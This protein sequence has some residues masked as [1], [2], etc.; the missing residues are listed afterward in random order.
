M[1][2]SGWTIERLRRE[3]QR[4]PFRCGEPALDE[5]LHK[6]AHQN[7]EKGIGRTFVATRPGDLVVL[8]YSTLRSGSVSTTVLQEA[9]RRHLPTYPVP[10]VHLGRL[11]VDQ[12][13]QGRRLG[14][15]LLVDALRRAEAASRDVAAYAVEV[16]A[17]HERAR[18]F[19]LKYGFREMTDDR[20]HRYLAMK[21]VKVLTGD[22]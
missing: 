22:E 9:D 13:M 7:D 10:V 4:A 8:G 1:A 2:D 19:Y 3:H 21:T 5:Y 12:S 18:G 17:I 14:E 20:L 6:Y 15:A 16:I 11:A